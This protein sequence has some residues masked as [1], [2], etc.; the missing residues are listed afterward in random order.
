MTGVAKKNEVS[1]DAQGKGRHAFSL[2]FFPLHV[3]WFGNTSGY[4]P[5]GQSVNYSF[6]LNYDSGKGNSRILLMT[7]KITSE[8]KSL[9]RVRI[10][11]PV[12]V[13]LK[14]EKDERNL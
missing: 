13:F 4:R 9:L 8:I 5:K 10:P 1:V 2:L 6:P 12:T 14:R 7:L 11:P 3:L